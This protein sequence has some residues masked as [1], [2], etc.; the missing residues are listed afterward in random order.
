MKLLAATLFSTDGLWE[1]AEFHGVSILHLA[2]A[3]S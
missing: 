2:T 1:V 3:D